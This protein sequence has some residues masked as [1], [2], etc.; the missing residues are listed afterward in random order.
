MDLA[1]FIVTALKAAALFEPSLGPVAAGFDEIEKTL[2]SPAGKQVEG[3]IESALAKFG[4]SLSAATV[5]MH[6]AHN[7]LTEQE[8]VMYNKTD[9]E[10]Y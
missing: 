10:G 5:G 4:S 6:N 3:H 2:A 9:N 8:E 1:A 7:H